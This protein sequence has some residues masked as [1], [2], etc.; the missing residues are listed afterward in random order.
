MNLGEIIRKLNFLEQRLS[1]QEAQENPKF[2]ATPE[3]N[4]TPIADSNGAL[5]IG[6]LQVKQ[7]VAAGETVT[8]HSG[9]SLVVAGDFTVDGDLIVDGDMSI[10]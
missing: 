10:G 1:N 7:S 8:I 2:T 6:W 4:T 5:A 9:Y 3:G